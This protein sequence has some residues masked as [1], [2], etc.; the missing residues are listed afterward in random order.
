[1]SQN[2]VLFIE[3]KLGTGIFF[4]LT[5]IKEPLHFK[6]FYICYCN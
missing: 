4:M 6:H 5:R 1:M 2:L 3:V